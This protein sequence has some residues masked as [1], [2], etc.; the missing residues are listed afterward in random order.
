MLHIKA[1]LSERDICTKFITPALVA[2]GWDIQKQVREEWSFTDGR[3]IV[4]GH[5]HTRGQRKRADY[6][7]S[8]KSTKLAIVEAKDNNH[9]VGHGMQQ[10]REYAD[11]LDIPFVYSSNGDAFLEHDK[12]KAGGEVE[13][14]LALGNFPRLKNYG[15]AM[16]LIKTWT[17]HSRRW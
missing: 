5:K 15:S 1:L 3:I 9:S 11:I 16:R 17:R 2:A 6:V 10:A 8:Y 7:L 14:E 13:K 4:R 12:T